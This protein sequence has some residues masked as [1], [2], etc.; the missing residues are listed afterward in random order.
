MDS[1]KLKKISALIICAIQLTFF[2]VTA[3]TNTQ[4]SKTSSYLLYK[5]ISKM[6]SLLFSAYNNVNIDKYKSFISE[7]VEFFHDKNGLIDSKR[8]IIKSLEKIAK[9][10]KHNS[11]SITRK[12][13]KNTF[14]VYEIPEFGALQTGVHQFIETNNGGSTSITK[15]KFIHI[16]KKQDGNWVIAKV[17]SFDH[18]PVKEKVNPNENAI[19]LTNKQMNVY[20][21]DYQFAPEFILTIVREGNK[22]FGIAQGDKIEI[23]PYEIH[24]F[25]ITRDNSK[26]EFL[27]DEKNSIIGIEMQ[28]KKGI[29]KAK[30]TNNK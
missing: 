12:L 10:K 5:E 17:F 24:K 23:K 11:Y 18:Q 19:S 15:A 21:G 14:E 26:L 25:L 13:I 27:V 2:S 20:L 29:M 9:A 1:I 6:D 3:Q 28:T 8:R 22:L 30:K 7:D 16:W 4:N